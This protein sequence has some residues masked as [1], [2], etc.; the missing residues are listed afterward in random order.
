[1]LIVPLPILTQ[2][3]GSIH[4]G[5]RPSAVLAA[6]IVTP[7]VAQAAREDMAGTAVAA[8]PRDRERKGRRPH[9]VPAVNGFLRFWNMACREP[10]SKDPPPLSLPKG[11]VTGHAGLETPD[12]HCFKKTH[13]LELAAEYAQSVP[14][15]VLAGAGRLRLENAR[16]ARRMGRMQDERDAEVAAPERTAK[17]TARRMEGAQLVG[18]RSGRRRRAGGRHVEPKR[19]AVGT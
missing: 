16:Q 3:T 7:C 19:A 8:C 5:Y 4:A 1:M 2:Y 6:G 14:A 15:L 10:L 9:D 13:V 18:G 17:E 12:R 11:Y